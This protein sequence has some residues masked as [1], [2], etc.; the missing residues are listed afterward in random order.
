MYGLPERNA[1][2]LRAK[3]DEFAAELV[4]DSRWFRRGGALAVLV[5]TLLT[6]LGLMAPAPILGSLGGTMN[7]LGVIGLVVGSRWLAR[8][9]ANSVYGDAIARAE[10]R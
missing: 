6:T 5:G 10:G 3:R 4:A 2:T 9:N 1:D 7:G 8:R